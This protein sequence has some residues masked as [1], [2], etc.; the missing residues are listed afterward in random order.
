LY[1]GTVKV[2][3]TVST[4]TGRRTAQAYLLPPAHMQYRVRYALWRVEASSPQEA[5]KIVIEAM[6]ANP[7][8][9]I[10]ISQ[11]EYKPLWKRLLWGY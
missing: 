10:F 6:K 9:F 3:P 11:D 5:K 8:G 1:G 7:S 2:E 4:L